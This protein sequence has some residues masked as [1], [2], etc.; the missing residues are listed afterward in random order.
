MGKPGDFSRRGLL[1]ISA[2]VATLPWLGALAPAEAATSRVLGSVSKHAV[3]KTKLYTSVSPAVFV[4]RTAS[5]SWTAFTNVCTHEGAQLA[6]QGSQAVCPL[7]GAVF[8]P[9]TGK[10]VAGPVSRSLRSR[11]ISARN[12]KIYITV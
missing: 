3:G 2:A 12:G 9:R 4:T 1:K 10:P 6:L 11:K 7:H 5:N 8:N